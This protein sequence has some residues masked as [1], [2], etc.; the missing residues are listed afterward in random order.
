MRHTLSALFTSAIGRKFLV[1]LTG[2]GLFGF[3]IGHLLGNLQIF[4][5]P[6]PLNA[7][8]ALLQASPALL[9]AARTGLFLAV[10]VHIGLSLQLARE[11][12][13]ARGTPYAVF[14]PPAASPAS[15]SMVRTGVVILVFVI[16]HLLHFTVRL[17]DPM[18]QNLHDALGRHD[19]YRMM[20]LG[21]SSWAVSL[22]YILAVGLLCL[23]LSHGVSSTAQSL[24]IR[25]RTV[26]ALERF[27]KGAALVLFLGYTSIPVAVL[28][29][30]VK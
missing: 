23:H 3:V 22:F 20:V 7:Y 6:E 29:G 12:R 14:K 11:N 15:L 24:G 30:F 5:G 18:Y 2:L 27:A 4:L 26:T 28:A 25:K 16:Y 10:L 8:A 9:W 13:A 17:T 1:A 19:V 21:F